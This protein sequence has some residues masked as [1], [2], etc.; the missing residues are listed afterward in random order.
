MADSNL[1]TRL[2]LAQRELMCDVW[3]FAAL[4]DH[5]GEPDNASPLVRV[6]VRHAQ[7]LSSSSEALE[8]LLAQVVSSGGMGGTPMS[9]QRDQQTYSGD[10]GLPEPSGVNS[11]GVAPAGGGVPIPSMR[12]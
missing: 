1:I 5:L 2:D 6:L 10:G 8:A 3:E 7:R 9:T 12:T 11:V 4:V